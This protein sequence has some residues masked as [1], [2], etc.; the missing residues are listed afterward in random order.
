M[1]R[2]TSIR[3]KAAFLLAVFVLNTLVGFA[4]ALGVNMGFN[5][6]HHHDKSHHHH[7]DQ[8]HHHHEQ[9]AVGHSHSTGEKGNCCNDEVVKFSQVD[10][11][12][13]QSIKAG[14]SPIFF[15]AFVSSFYNINLLYTFQTPIPGKSFLRSYHP[16]IADI[17]IA[18]Q[19]FQI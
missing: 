2:S 7:H 11:S 14:I 12:T 16:P 5:H 18:V 9:A 8:L 13:P 10:K 17:R 15:T 19:S 1:E 4:C 6:P 3:L